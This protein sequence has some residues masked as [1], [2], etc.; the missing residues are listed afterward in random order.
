MSP[1]RLWHG[2]VLHRSCP[3]RPFCSAL[4]PDGGR[5]SPFIFF[6][7]EISAPC[8]AE[9]TL[10]GRAIC[11]AQAPT[12]HFRWRCCG[13]PLSPLTL[14]PLPCSYPSDTYLAMSEPSSG[15]ASPPTSSGPPIPAAPPSRQEIERR[16]SISLPKPQ[17]PPADS[18]PK[19]VRVRLFLAVPLMFLLLSH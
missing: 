13:S 9:A 4:D 5:T 19:M 12:C 3:G 1:V 6:D 18:K 2:A 15:L 14:T 8:C 10:M 16:L 17:I 11:G 7:L